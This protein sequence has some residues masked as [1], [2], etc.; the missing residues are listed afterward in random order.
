MTFQK[1]QKS[2]H[3]AAKGN[4][5]ATKHSV[6]YFQRLLNG[7]LDHRTRLNRVLR[8]KERDL[9]AALG[10]DPSPQE[11]IL[12]A[13][14]VKNILYIGTIDEYL[15]SLDGGIIRQFK[16]IPVVDTRTKLASHLRDNLRALGLHRRVKQVTLTEMLAQH[17]E[18]EKESE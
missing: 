5:L 15:M 10:G 16:V 2:P 6:Y 7:K 11:R 13:D 18:P 17:D 12:I 4:T 1:G 8:E 14:A 9:I 3:P